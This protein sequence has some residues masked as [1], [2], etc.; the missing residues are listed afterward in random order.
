VTLNPGA[1]TGK[2]YKLTYEGS[3]VAGPKTDIPTGQGKVTLTGMDALIEAMKSAPEDMRMQAMM[4]LGAL[5]GM[6]KKGE[7]GALVWEID[8]ATPGKV[9]LNGMDLT[10]IGGGQ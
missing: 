8:G 2:D 7:D 6:A 1:T 5:R 9:L 4:G 10:K 3:L